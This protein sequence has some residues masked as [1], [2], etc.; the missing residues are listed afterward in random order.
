MAR[1]PLDQ[2]IPEEVGSTVLAQVSETSA[3][4][5]LATREPMGTDA[6]VVPSVNGIAVSVVEKG[7]AY[8]EDV[9]ADG[10]LTLKA[11]KF[12]TAIRMA[13]EDLKDS[14]VNVIAA[15]QKSWARSY[16]IKLDNAALGTTA[17][18]NGGTVPFTS[19]YRKVSQEAAANIIKTAGAVTY[20]HFSNALGLVEGSDFNENIVVIANPAFK[21]AFRNVKDDNGSPVFVQGLAGTPDSVFG[22]RVVW[23]AGARTSAEASSAPKGNPLLIVANA[24]HL[25]LGVRSGP[26]SAFA[27]ADS[28]AAFMTDEAL[29]KM[30]SRRAFAAGDPTAFAIVEVTG[31]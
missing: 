30:R 20:D 5:A 12:G 17:A 3:V 23:S 22:Y 8:P 29:L 6:K 2:W 14:P 25:L 13:D 11:R 1:Q 24:D 4:E 15:K 10:E 26:E 28:G 7:T 21:A 31:A 16:A 18:E 9:T 27:P 19:V